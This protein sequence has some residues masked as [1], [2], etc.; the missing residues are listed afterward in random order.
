MISATSVF[1]ISLHD[2]GYPAHAQSTWSFRVH[3]DR[4]TA[5]SLE[6]HQR[7]NCWGIFRPAS[8]GGRFFPSSLDVIFKERIC[9]SLLARPKNAI[10]PQKNDSSCP[11]P[12][13]MLCIL[14]IR[15]H[16]NATT[17]YVSVDTTTTNN[18]GPS[19]AGT[20]G[21]DGG[22]SSPILCSFRRSHHP[23][24]GESPLNVGCM[25]PSSH[26]TAA[27]TI[28]R[29]ILVFPRNGAGQGLTDEAG[30]YVPRS[31]R[32]DVFSECHEDFEVNQSLSPLYEAPN[33]FKPCKLARKVDSV[34]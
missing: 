14:C 27:V 31:T 32:C 26:T 33:T 19:F 13:M 29:P 28:G 18:T 15:S 22:R 5:L 6:I 16:Q 17:I 1:R 30:L 9:L 4:D 10:V 8:T 20:K 21:F 3:C 23:R 2:T 25:Y 7:N 24:A 11:Y 12:S 34:E